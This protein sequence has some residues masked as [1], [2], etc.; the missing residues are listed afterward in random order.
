MR[1]HITA[2]TAL[3]CTGAMFLS[4]AVGTAHEGASAE[5]SATD[6]G[7]VDFPISCTS[8][9][10]LG[11]ERGVALMHHMMYGQALEQF[12]KVAKDDSQCAMAHWGIAMTYFHPLWPPPRTSDL[13][14]GLAAVEQ[15]KTRNAPTD[16]EKAYIAAA[17]SFFGN[18]ETIHHR[19][20]RAAWEAA[21]ENIYIAYPNDI[22]A[23]AFYALAHL[24]TAPKSDT[25][26]A[27]Q[28]KAGAQLE[29]LHAKA[30]KHPGLFHYTIH[31][32]DNPMLADRAVAVA[33]GYN[34]LAPQIPHALHMPTHIF[35]RLGLWPEVIDWNTRSAS[36]AITNTKQGAASFHRI[37]AQDY[38]IYAHLQQGQD[39][40]AEGVLQAVNNTD[41]YQDSFASAYGIA[42]VQA[43]SVLEHGEWDKAATLPLRTHQSFPWDKYPWF[44]SITHFARGLGAARSGDLTAAQ[45]AH[46]TLHDAYE[47]TIT[48]GQKYWAIQIDVQ[49]QTVSSWMAYARG[50]SD[51]ALTM[52]SEAAALEDSVDKHP[53]TPG[54]VLPA[55]EL[56]GEM[57]LLTGKPKEALQAY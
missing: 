9:A 48:A 33:R 44:E 8:S 19:T 17:E 41:T 32:Y 3:L 14:Q 16:R 4:A 6:L 54:S 26:F 43:R 28:Q 46:T 57:L 5:A 50:E 15:A 37:H 22:E 2:L 7:S 49:R 29:A 35:V 21:Q 42:A 53:V 1:L 23:G 38:L 45:Q 52:M 12:E 47:R 18:W 30:P 40:Q 13:K 27:H 51:H 31:A 56:Y 20:R 55:R 34:V 39:A 24:S 25:T 10:Q 36:A 11:F